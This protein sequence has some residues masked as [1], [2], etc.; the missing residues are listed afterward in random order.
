[1]SFIEIAVDYVAF[2]LSVADLLKDSPLGAEYAKGI[3]F[4]GWSSITRLMDLAKAVVSSVEIVKQNAIARC[5]HEGACKFPQDVA[6]ETAISL[7]DD[8]VVFK[9]WGGAIVEKYDRAFL[10]GLV[11][12]A[13][14]GLEG[15]S[16]LALARATLGIL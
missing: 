10:V 14:H 1:M 13:L 11:K 16:W 3:E 6:L 8:L 7:M 4:N 12:L 5:A 2:R 15:K 9:G